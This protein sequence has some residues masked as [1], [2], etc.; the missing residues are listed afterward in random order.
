M[1]STYILNNLFVK[2]IPD[3][4]IVLNMCEKML[5]QRA[6]AFQTVVKMGA[7]MKKNLPNHIKIDKVKGRTFHFPLPLEE[8]FQK[9]CPDSDRLNVN[10]ELFI[11]VRSNPTKTKIIWEDY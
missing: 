9:I 2:E 1:P 10:H 3:Q 8:T 6:K 5:I 11:L 7:V 4:L